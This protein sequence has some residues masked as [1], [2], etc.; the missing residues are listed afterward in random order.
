MSPAFFHCA[1]VAG[2]FIAGSSWAQVTAAE[3]SDDLYQA[4]EAV[5]AWLMATSEDRAG[6][7]EDLKRYDGGCELM[8]ARRRSIRQLQLRSEFLYRAEHAD[9]PSAGRS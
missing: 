9:V 4:V 7:E 8:I 3:Q 2:L 6:L 5:R 1:A